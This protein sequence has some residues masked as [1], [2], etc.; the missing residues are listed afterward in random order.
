[1]QSSC[2][3]SEENMSLNKKRI[4]RTVKLNDTTVWVT[5]DTEQEYADK[6]MK[7]AGAEKNGSGEKH[8]FAEYAHRW[9]EVFSKPNVAVVTALTYESQMKKHILPILG[10]KTVEDI[11]PADIQKVFNYMSKDAKQ[12]TKNKV[13][14][15]LSQ[16]LKMAVEEEVI[17]RNPLQSSSL[18]IKGQASAVTKP[19][20]V[21][22]MR[23]LAGH[24]G[25]IPQETDRVWLAL[26][27]SLPLR[28]EEVLGLTWAD[29]DEEN[30]ILHIRNTVTHPT[31]NEPEFKP[32]TKTAASVRDLVFPREVLRYL[33]KR[34]KPE[35]FVVGGRNPIS[36]TQ[37]R[38][39]R[40]RITYALH[41]DETITP[42]RFR[43][44]VATDI[45]ATTHDLKLVQRM[46]GHSTPQMTLKHYDKGRSTASDAA[47][48]ISRCYG[49]DGPADVHIM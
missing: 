15:V 40:K 17:S 37:L 42:R 16:I 13:K 9:F 31:R 4:R 18:R 44:T 24:L 6:L 34:G 21:E 25:H 33:P 38:G 45:S 26:S 11:T 23:Y 12:E 22:Q 8:S 36:Y 29:V 48:A 19:Y 43:T 32:Y 27:I 2:T 35:E 3:E 5:A 14:N 49:F 7:I 10:E 47:Q 1:M 30:C 46:L 41:F 39:V 20:T 28:L